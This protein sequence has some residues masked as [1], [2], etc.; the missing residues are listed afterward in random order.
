MKWP[1]A[2]GGHNIFLRSTSLFRILTTNMTGRRFCFNLQA[3]II[4]LDSVEM[5]VHFRLRATHS[6]TAPRRHL[7]FPVIHSTESLISKCKCPPRHRY[8]SVRYS[9]NPINVDQLSFISILSRVFLVISWTQDDASFRLPILKK[10][11]SRHFS[12][13]DREE[14]P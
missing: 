7:C 9:Y 3:R 5:Q 6:P 1:A 14:M 8:W 12:I 4:P 10:H 13:D 11:H 2:E